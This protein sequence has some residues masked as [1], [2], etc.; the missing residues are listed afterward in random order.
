MMYVI[1]PPM[2]VTEVLSP[3]IVT[4]APREWRSRCYICEIGDGT[5]EKAN[6]RELAILQYH[7][8]SQ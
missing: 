3:T 4:Y 1:G 2:D 8:R 6:I 7:L 5:A